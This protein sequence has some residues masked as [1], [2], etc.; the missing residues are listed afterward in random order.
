MQLYSRA[1][2]SF[3]IA[4]HGMLLYLGSVNNCLCLGGPIFI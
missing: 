3:V 1:K 2:N 4:M